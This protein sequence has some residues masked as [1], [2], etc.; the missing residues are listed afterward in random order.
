MCRSQFRRS[1]CTVRRSTPSR[2][3]AR[4][5]CA[6]APLRSAQRTSS[7][8]VQSVPGRHDPLCLDSRQAAPSA[9]RQTKVSTCPD[10]APAVQHVSE[11]R[12]SAKPSILRYSGGPFLLYH[13]LLPV[14]AGR[15]L[16]PRLTF[17]KRTAE[18][19]GG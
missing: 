19:R 5:S 16:P 14:L 12:L 8:A 11:V 13:R 6:V 18:V 1:K 10:S 9:E 7:W 4:L 17:G 3:R 15:N 2:P